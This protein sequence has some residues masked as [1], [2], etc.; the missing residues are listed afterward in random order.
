LNKLIAWLCVASAALCV[1]SIAW[2][3]SPSSTDVKK[4]GTTLDVIIVQTDS[5]VAAAA[6]TT[7]IDLK[8]MAWLSAGNAAGLHYS[9][10]NILNDSTVGDSLSIVVNT[11]I[12]GQ[13]WTA[14]ITAFILNGQAAAEKALNV[15]GRY[16]RFI[17]T[18]NDVNDHPYNVRMWALRGN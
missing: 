8:D 12:D 16:A 9:N 1:T 6:D 7:V 14:D 3:G 10:V 11:S 2:A 18:N 5:L 17:I 4:S 13:V 15:P